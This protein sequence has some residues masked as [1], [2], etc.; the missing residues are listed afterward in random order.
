MGTRYF[1]V[2]GQ[3]VSDPR[4]TRAWRRL[5]DKVVAEEPL[6]WLGLEG[7]T[8]VSTTGDHVIPVSERPDLAL[9]RDNV[10]GACGPCN[11]KRGKLPVSALNLEG[12]SAALDI[13]KGRRS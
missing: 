4:S 13:F 10:R 7:C 9:V 1:I 8:G 12:P 11:D 3:T 5:L 6:C 2:D